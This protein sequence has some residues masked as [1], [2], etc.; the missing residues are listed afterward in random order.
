MNID[1]PL[2]RAIGKYREGARCCVM[3]AQY[4]RY[5]PTTPGALGSGEGRAIALINACLD[6]FYLYPAYINDGKGATADLTTDERT[7]A[8]QLAILAAGHTPVI[9]ER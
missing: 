6:A 5:R 3:G 2:D 8:L 7:M 1:L 9:V 4:P